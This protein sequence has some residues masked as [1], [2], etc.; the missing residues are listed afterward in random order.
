MFFRGGRWD[1]KT[2]PLL[3]RGILP[4]YRGRSSSSVIRLEGPARSEAAF[5][6]N[7][8][9]KLVLYESPLQDLDHTA[10]ANRME[11]MIRAE[12]DRA[13]AGVRDVPAGNRDDLAG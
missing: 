3:T 9:S 8:I 12:L 5:L 2:T 11:T 6:T 1:S 4:R 13:R 7:K 10:V